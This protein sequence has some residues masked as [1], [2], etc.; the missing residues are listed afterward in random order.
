M[1]ERLTIS[2]LTL[3]C[4]APVAAQDLAEQVWDAGRMDEFAAVTRMEDIASAQNIAAAWLPY[5]SDFTNVEALYIAPTVRDAIHAAFIAALD[6]DHAEEILAFLRSEPGQAMTAHELEGRKEFYDDSALEEGRAMLTA[7]VFTEPEK[8]E[9]LSD[10]IEVNDL[11]EQNLVIG[12][13]FEMALNAGASEVLPPELQTDPSLL[14]SQLQSEA[15]WMRADITDWLESYLAYS[16]GDVP[17][18][19]FREI[20][21]FSVTEAGQAYN[22]ALFDAYA[23]Y[24]EV[25]ARRLGKT[26][27]EMTMATQL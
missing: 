27:M 3:L 9:L 15:E 1:F 6:E 19:Q 11:I 23:A 5:E 24:S 17:E 10:Y 25:A 4:A 12:L 2:F 7:M 22:T 20:F 13:N 16:Y 8:Y 18:D 14:A 21:E 26:L